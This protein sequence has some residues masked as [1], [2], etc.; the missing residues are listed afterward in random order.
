M[1]TIC[2]RM[3]ACWEEVR[4][5]D[6]VD[7]EGM[8]LS[9]RHDH[10]CLALNVEVPPWQ[11]AATDVECVRHLHRDNITRGLGAGRA[12]RRGG[13]KRQS[14]GARL[15]I[16]VHLGLGLWGA[17]VDAVDDGVTRALLR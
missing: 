4:P 9:A 1:R 13:R 15:H 16:G 17:A 8:A 2:W 12:E 5:P 6:R 3:K 11:H 7:M 10:P 14:D